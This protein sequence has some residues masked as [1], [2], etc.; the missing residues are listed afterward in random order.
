MGAF[1]VTIKEKFT[2]KPIITRID[3]VETEDAVKK[4]YGLDGD[5]IEWY[6]I[7]KLQR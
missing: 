1:R 2:D 7:E 3:G 4:F 5:D 6:E